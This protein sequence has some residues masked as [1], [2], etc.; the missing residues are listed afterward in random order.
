[1]GEALKKLLILSLAVGMLSACGKSKSGNPEIPAPAPTEPDV[2]PPPIGDGT[3]D[4]DGGGWEPD[5]GHTVTFYPDLAEYNTFVAVA[6][7]NNPTNFKIT[8]DLEN[9]NTATEPR[10][11]GKILLS[12]TDN[13]Q[14]RKG[15][16]QADSERNQKFDG[17]SKDNKLLDGHYNFWHLIGEKKVFSG[18]FEDDIGAIVLVIDQQMDEG[19]A[20]GGSLWSGKVYYKN[21][22]TTFAPKSPY[23]SCWF[24]YNNYKNYDCRANPIINKS[25]TVPGNGYRLLGTFRGLDPSKAFQE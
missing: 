24:I 8:V 1:M 22:A 23:R 2:L 17:N 14:R 19:D 6:P 4:D 7:L 25:S 15:T 18:F 3:G 5:G 13:G 10:Y 11:A 9:A 20:S 21:F 16:L 12:Y